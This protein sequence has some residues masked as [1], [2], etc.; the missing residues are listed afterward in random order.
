MTDLKVYTPSD[1]IIIAIVFKII[2]LFN[3]Y[4]L[5]ICEH[6]NNNL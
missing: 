4:A 5:F 2:C 3:S 1:F 6:I